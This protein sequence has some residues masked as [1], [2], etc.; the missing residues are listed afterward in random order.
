MIFKDRTFTPSSVQLECKSILS[1]SQTV[2]SDLDFRLGH[3]RLL[4][5]GLWR[6]DGLPISRMTRGVKFTCPVPHSGPSAL[7]YLP[8]GLLGVPLMDRDTPYSEYV[9][10]QKESKGWDRSEDR[11]YRLSCHSCFP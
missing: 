1:H 6:A 10:N 5:S 2:I 11:C 3:C 4:L 9:T 8:D 7:G